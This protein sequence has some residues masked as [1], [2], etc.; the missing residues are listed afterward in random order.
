MPLETSLIFTSV[1]LVCNLKY[2]ETC[3][4]ELDNPFWKFSKQ[5]YSVEAFRVIN[6]YKNRSPVTYQMEDMSK[7]PILERTSIIC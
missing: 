5:P 7:T 1:L 4:R 3:F 2:N 6:I